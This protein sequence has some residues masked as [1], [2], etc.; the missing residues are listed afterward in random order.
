MVPR[1][2]KLGI[3]MLVVFAGFTEQEEEF[4]VVLDGANANMIELVDLSE[5]SDDGK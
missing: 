4:I 3:L 5:D 2:R 1:T